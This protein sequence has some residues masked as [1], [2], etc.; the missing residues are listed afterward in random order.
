MMEE[1]LFHRGVCD[2]YMSTSCSMIAYL[3]NQL[4]KKWL[5]YDA[6]SLVD[7]FPTERKRKARKSSG[8]L[9]LQ[10]TASW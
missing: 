9:A 7:I 4:V 2:F 10:S 8:C 3:I 5:L 6:F 1:E